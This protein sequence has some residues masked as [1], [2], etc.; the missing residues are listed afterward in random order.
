[1]NRLLNNWPLKLTALI[2]SIALWSHVRGESNPLETQTFSVKL[3]VHPPQNMPVGATDAP[4]T[5][6]VTVRAPHQELRIMGGVT[7]PLANPLTSP[8]GD[9]P[10]VANNIL[11]A[12]LD[13]S[14]VSQVSNR[15]QTIPIRVDSDSEDVEVLGVKPANVSVTLGKMR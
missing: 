2:L 9:V 10:S 5:V 14:D 7:L 12:S 13:F 1:M 4:K 3:D 8:D 11:K 15:P 6:R